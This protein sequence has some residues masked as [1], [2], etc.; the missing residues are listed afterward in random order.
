MKAE[1][2]CWLLQRSGKITQRRS[3]VA[4]GVLFTVDDEIME[5]GKDC[6]DKCHQSNKRN[7]EMNGD[8]T[9]EDI[10]KITKKT[11]C[12]ITISIHSAELKTHLSN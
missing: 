9:S 7:D 1:S 12:F 3:T 10:G 2:L 4:G 11:Y 8:N 6:M 5:A